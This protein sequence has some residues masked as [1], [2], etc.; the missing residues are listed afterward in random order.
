MLIESFMQGE[1]PSA[2]LL[3]ILNSG[4]A[5][6]PAPLPGKSKKPNGSVIEIANYIHALFFKINVVVGTLIEQNILQDRSSHLSM[7]EKV[8]KWVPVVTYWR[9]QQWL[10]RMAEF[11]EQAHKFD[12][13]LY[14]EESVDASKMNYEEITRHVLERGE[15]Q[16]RYFFQG[17]HPGKDMIDFVVGYL[18]MTFNNSIIGSIGVRRVS[19]GGAGTVTG[20]ESSYQR[21]NQKLKA[22]T[23]KL[24]KD[25][26][27]IRDQPRDRHEE[28]FNDA[29]NILLY[30]IWKGWL[31]FPK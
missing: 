18:Q 16:R 15:Q 8:M 1:K 9:E 2:K 3:S 14:P 19:V 10:P 30:W 28:V 11:D 29:Y 6:F 31:T 24:A 22:A 4:F 12:A 17:A 27:W 26:F 21:W 5:A 20:Q 23:Q 7:Y 13:E 25:I